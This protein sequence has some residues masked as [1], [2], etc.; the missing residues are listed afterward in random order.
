MAYIS[1]CKTESGPSLKVNEDA[2]AVFVKHDVLYQLLSDG[3]SSVGDMK[4]AGFVIN[5]I[6]RYIERFSEPD[7]DASPIKKQIEQACYTANRVLMAY[8]RANNEIYTSSNFATLTM[9]AICKD[10]SFIYA[11]CGDSRLYIIRNGKI[12]QLTK[13]HTEAQRLCDEGKI[14]RSQV[15]S[16]PDNVILTSALGFTEPKIDVVSGKL[17]SGDILLALTDGIHKV[18]SPDQLLAVAEQA[19]NCED[20]CDGLIKYAVNQGGNDD[21]AVFVTY[22]PS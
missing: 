13:D 2:V 5:E 14:E 1:A 12:I 21:K 19:G 20:T 22:I 10:N 11:H 16:H 17:Q 18:L 8:K 7:L 15:F 3:N 9:A 6:Q 4:P